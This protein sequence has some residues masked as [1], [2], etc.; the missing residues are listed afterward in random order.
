MIAFLRGKL[1]LILDEAIWLDVNGVGYEI[2]IHQRILQQMPQPGTEMTIFTYMAVQEN[3]TRLYGF[4][5]QEE[6]NL[7][8]LLIGV[9]GIGSKVA[10]NIVA[11]MTPAQFCQAILSGDEKKLLI[12]PGIGKKTASRLVFELKDRLSKTNIEVADQRVSGP[13]IGELLE[14]L[15]A[16]GYG[17]SE[18]YP[19]IINVQG[20]LTEKVEDNLKIVLKT[21]ADQ[22]KK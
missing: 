19:V 2:N 4:L 9:S 17:R 18:V 1:F 3:E 21:L 16:L 11:T 8:K 7:F 20:N 22:N 6:L 12:I 10:Q 13:N 15:E 14:A 5:Y